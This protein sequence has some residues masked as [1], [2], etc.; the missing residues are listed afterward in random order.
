MLLFP[1]DKKLGRNIGSSCKLLVRIISCCP[2]PPQ[3][4]NFRIR[5]LPLVTSCVLWYSSFSGRLTK[6]SPM[7][8]CWLEQSN[9]HHFHFS[10]RALQ[11]TIIPD[12]SDITLVAGFSTAPDRFWMF[13]WFSSEQ[14]WSTFQ[15]LLPLPVNP[16]KNISG[17]VTNSFT[18]ADENRNMGYVV[19]VFM[20]RISLQRVTDQDLVLNRHLLA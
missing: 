18:S 5:C 1:H 7:L 6:L 17:Y 14:N 12:Q 16:S 15:R 20:W 8:P 10:G 11:E 4:Q 13:C 19:V 2:I 3:D 9:L